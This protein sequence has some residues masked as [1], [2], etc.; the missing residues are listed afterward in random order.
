V[1]TAL[2]LVMLQEAIA[3][4]GQRSAQLKQNVKLLGIVLVKNLLQLCC[5][6]KMA[7]SI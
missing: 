4:S 3:P 6:L 2:E 7:E 1:N 5:S